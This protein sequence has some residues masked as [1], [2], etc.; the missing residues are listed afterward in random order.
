M[1][2]EHHH[3]HFH[4]FMKWRFIMMSRPLKSL[5]KHMESRNYS[6]MLV[7]VTSA[8]R[9]TY[10]VRIAYQAYS[11]KNVNAISRLSLISRFLLCTFRV[12]VIRVSCTC[13]CTNKKELEDM[14][15]YCV[16][17]RLP[18]PNSFIDIQWPFNVHIH[19]LQIF[20]MCTHREHTHPPH[21]HTHILLLL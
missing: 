13:A 1:K 3:H 17:P 19:F 20:T 10:V 21:N 4:T 9:I 16:I 15:L 11:Q 12:C 2:N 8:N 14:A 5:S 6:R 18:I 7:K